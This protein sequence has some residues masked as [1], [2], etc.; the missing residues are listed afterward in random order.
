VPPLRLTLPAGGL[1]IAVLLSL[2]GCSGTGSNNSSGTATELDSSASDSGGTTAGP[3]PVDI[4]ACALVAVEDVSAAVGQTLEV[5]GELPDSCTYASGSDAAL[6]VEISAAPDTTPLGFE[7]L[8]AFLEETYGG[9]A[10]VIDLGT[11]PGLII[12][13]QQ[14]GQTGKAAGAAVGG[15][16]V[17]VVLVGGDPATQAEVVMRILGLVVAPQ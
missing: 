3:P 15:F 7:G 1:V 8:G 9:F 6:M 2:S 11:T 12:D 16:I 5:S 4:G 14:D 10:E 13:I 17:V